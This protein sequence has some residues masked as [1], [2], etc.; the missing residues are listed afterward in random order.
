MTAS[1]RIAIVHYH[2]RPGGVTRVIRNAVTA[3]K[4]RGR[5]VVVLTGRPPPDD[6]AGSLPY[7][8]VNGLD[9]DVAMDA[10]PAE[11]LRRLKRGAFDALGAEPDVWHIHN[12][13]IGK[14]VALPEVCQALA[15]EG[16]RLLLQIH[17]F[18]ED[19]RPGNYRLLKEYYGDRLGET[20]YPDG[21]NVHYALLNARDFDVMN[22]AGVPSR[23]LHSLPNAVWAGIG[24][25]CGSR[26]DLGSYQ[27]LFLYPTRAIRRK[28]IGEFILWSVLAKPGDLYATTLAPTSAGDLPI[29]DGWKALAA[30]LE[31]PVRFEM[32]MQ[33]AFA[34]IVHTAAA[35]VTTSIAEGF[36]LAF[37]EPW[38]ASKPLLGRDLPEITRE[39]VEQGVDLSWL[40]PALEVPRTWIDERRFRSVMEEACR[41]AW[42]SYGKTCDAG[43]VDQAYD[44]AFQGD[45]IEFA[46][47]D[48]SSQ[49][50]II[51]KLA[52]DGTRRRRIRPDGIDLPESSSTVLENNRSI[53]RDRYG[54]PR[55]GER[56]ES[57][58]HALLDD[59][60]TDSGNLSADAVLDAF[61]QPA[62]FY[63]MRS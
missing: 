8:A 54:L 42:M 17:D 18:A 49:A 11:L 30:E 3:L 39:F 32:G 48:E 12:H 7:A 22:G 63:L 58:Y 19:G 14:N 16:R 9:Y 60:G 35:F 25:D 38:L 23:R 15:R 51:R 29:Y 56:L 46:R 52:S 21:G 1:L 59:S 57:I 10:D 24:V 40:Y 27:R 47:L 20:L 53:I 5:Q 43:R 28:N 4:D 45:R 33:H 31:L 26:V 36:G 62:R 50:E 6:P 61:L 37:L 34:D 13:S 2:L 41:S 55:Y 44:A